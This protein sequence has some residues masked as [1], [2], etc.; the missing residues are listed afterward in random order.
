MATIETAAVKKPQPL[1][2]SVCV[3]SVL[4][5]LV[6]HSGQYGELGCPQNG[7]D[8]HHRRHSAL[9]S[10][11]VPGFTGT[12]TQHPQTLYYTQTHLIDSHRPAADG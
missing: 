5:L 6:G 11:C 12:N 2:D 4:V 1:P 9:V 7:H 8:L 3:F 10:V